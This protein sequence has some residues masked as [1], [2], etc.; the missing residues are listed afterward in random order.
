MQSIQLAFKLRDWLWL[1][2]NFDYIV[3]WKQD[4]TVILHELKGAPFRLSLVLNL[5]SIPLYRPAVIG[6]NGSTPFALLSVLH[7]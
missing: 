7:R 2:N 4:I 6:Y 1:T 3:V 5:R